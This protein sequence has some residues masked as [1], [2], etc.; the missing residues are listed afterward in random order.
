MNK[1]QK[2]DPQAPVSSTPMEM[3]EHAISQGA[4]VEVMEKLL[5]LQERWEGNQ[6]RKAFDAAMADIRPKM[7]EIVKSRH[8]DF[9]NKNGGRTKYDHEDL[10][11]I[12]NAVDPV[13]AAHG[14][15]YHWKTDTSGE[16]NQVSVTC[17]V[18]HRDGH[19]EE[20]SLSAP[21]DNSG[22]KN[23]IQSIGSTVTYLQRYTLKA[24]LGL[25]AGPDTDG[26][27]P[28]DNTP[29]DAGQLKKLTSLADEV[30]ADIPRFCRHMKI[31]KI[32]DLP[33]RRFDEAIRTLEAKRQVAK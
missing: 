18:S 5:A 32:A 1:V 12:S 24:A 16:S 8:V 3:L 15:S 19:S 17:I 29:I 22:N 9:Q 7:P 2:I 28:L 11:I 6:A 14:L 31:N 30:S 33:A 4:S 26:N 13:L 23:A 25:A 10:S 27:V 20:T 21:H